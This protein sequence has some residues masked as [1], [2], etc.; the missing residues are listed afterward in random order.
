MVHGAA[1][2]KR[3]PRLTERGFESH[4]LRQK[5]GIMDKIY[6]A[7][8][9]SRDPKVKYGCSKNLLAITEKN[10]SEIYPQLDFFIKLLDDE[11]KILKW[12]AID[13]IGH[14]AKVDKNKS[15]DKLMERLFSLLSEGNLITANHAITALT[16]VTLAKPEYQKKITNELLKVEHYSYDTDECRNIATGKVILAISTYFGELEDKKAVIEFAKRQTKNTRNAT[17][18]KAEQFLKKYDQQD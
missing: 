1:L 18:K 15:I 7:D 13:I 9:S 4:P 3:S 6:L 12:T 17:R 11:N 10:P 5:E 8:L 16:D 14:L 2:E